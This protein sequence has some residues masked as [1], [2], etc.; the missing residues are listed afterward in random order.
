[1]FLKTF[2]YTRED[3]QVGLFHCPMALDGEGADWIQEGE[4]TANPYYGS[5]MLRCGSLT[6]LL[7][8]EN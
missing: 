1:M 7:S 5:E 8:Q 6:E 2:G 3:G 4:E